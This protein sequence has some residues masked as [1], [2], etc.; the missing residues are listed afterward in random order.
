MCQLDF[1]MV[2]LWFLEDH[3]LQPFLFVLPEIKITNE[4]VQAWQNWQ[5][6]LMKT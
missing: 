2:S 3:H 5:K 6:M 1:F 4:A